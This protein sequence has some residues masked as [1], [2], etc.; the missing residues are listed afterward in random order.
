MMTPAGLRE[1]ARY[2]TEIGPWKESILP[3]DK[4]NRLGKAGT[5][6]D[7]AHAAGLD[8]VAYTFRPEN[9]FLPL[10]LRSSANPVEYG[11]AIA[12]FKQFFALGVDGV[13][14]DNADIAKAAR[15][16]E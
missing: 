5:L 10:E 9:T 2:A 6:I 1:I 8:V 3:R 7:D 15:D 13:F 11:D 16:G 4:E 12:E 14:T